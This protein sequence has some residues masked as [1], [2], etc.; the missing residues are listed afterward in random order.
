[1][2]HDPGQARSDQGGRAE[3]MAGQLANDGLSLQKSGSWRKVSVSL[4][5]Q[6]QS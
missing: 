2:S 4:G 3:V 1:M 6:P 5:E